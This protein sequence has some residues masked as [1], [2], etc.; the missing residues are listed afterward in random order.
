MP[1]FGYRYIF[2]GVFKPLQVV[3]YLEDIFE[4]SQDEKQECECF[5]YTC[6]LA[7]SKATL[8]ASTYPW[9]QGSLDRALR[10]NPLDRRRGRSSNCR[11]WGIFQF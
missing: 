10:R 4:S 8:E 6:F 7:K 1:S 11:P 9:C 2:K 3:R 5:S